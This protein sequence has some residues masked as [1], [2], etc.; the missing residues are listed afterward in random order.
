MTGNPWYDGLI[1]SSI[2]FFNIFCFVGTI[3]FFFGFVVLAQI[4]N[5]VK[6][7]NHV[8]IEKLDMVSDSIA[9]WSWLSGP[10]LSIVGGLFAGRKKRSWRRF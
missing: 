5:A 7:T 10:A 6:Q 3:L 8:I 2:I 4:N 1:I 9:D